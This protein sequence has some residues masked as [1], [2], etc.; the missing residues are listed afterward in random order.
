MPKTIRDPGLRTSGP[1]WAWAATGPGLK[2]RPLDAARAAGPLVGSDNP[3]IPA[4]SYSAGP[5]AAAGGKPQS[6]MA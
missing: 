3:A 4:A 2:C 1:G 5:G 6:I